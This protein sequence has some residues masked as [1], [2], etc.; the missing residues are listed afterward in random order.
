MDECIGPTDSVKTETVPLFESP[1]IEAGI[2]KDVSSQSGG[3]APVGQHYC[4]ICLRR[5]SLDDPTTHSEIRAW[6]RGTKK[7]SAVLR[8]YTG[9]LACG[10]CI[11]RIRAGVGANTPD[12][13][14]ALD[15]IAPAPQDNRGAIFTD[16]SAA[17]RTGYDDG[18]HGRPSECFAYVLDED[19]EDEYRTGWSDGLA[20][21]E[22]R[23]INA[24]LEK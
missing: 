18:L 5:V 9:N 3:D 23:L 11:A 15:S 4:S 17:Y 2:A 20:Q 16:M 21:R 24:N 6:V 22:I 13:E 10:D 14:T 7:D 1:G 8:Q 19:G 12:F